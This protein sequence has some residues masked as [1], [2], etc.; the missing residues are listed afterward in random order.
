M[1]GSIEYGKCEMCGTI[2]PLIRKYYYYGIKCECHSPEHFELVR[3]CKGCKP[4][5]P[6]RTTISMNPTSER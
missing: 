4:K 5:P 6:K 2:G 1:G 3:H